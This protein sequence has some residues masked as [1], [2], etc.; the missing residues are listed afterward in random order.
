[1]TGSRRNRFA[2]EVTGV[3]ID[4]VEVPRMD[5]AL[6]RWGERF[7]AR[8][9]TKGE[10]DYSRQFMRPAQHLSARFAGKEAVVK[11]LGTGFSRGCRMNEIEILPD[12]QGRP[13]VRLHGTARRLAA[14]RG[15]SKIHLSLSHSG[16]TAVAQAVAVGRVVDEEDGHAV[17]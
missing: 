12:K 14:D 16:K 3:G 11:A 6:G 1:M 2:G 15:V 5:R 13:L 8:V 7:A 9:F 4:I 17:S 10:L